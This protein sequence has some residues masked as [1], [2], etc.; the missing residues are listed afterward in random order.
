MT[1]TPTPSVWDELRRT[2]DELE[3]KAHLGSMELRD[4]WRLLQPRL[5]R[6]EKMME[7]K[8]AE[9]TTWIAEELGNLSAAVRELRDDMVARAKG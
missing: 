2:T 6:L 3:L 7:V 1:T 4:R 9:A 5:A 8:T